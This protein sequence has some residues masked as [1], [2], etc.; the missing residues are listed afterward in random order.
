MDALAISVGNVHGT[1]NGEP[2]LDFE[3]IEKINM[4][5]ETDCIPHENSVICIP[6]I[7]MLKNITFS[8]DV[9]IINA[10][11]KKALNNNTSLNALFNSWLAG[12]VKN[13]DS[14]A[15]LETFLDKVKYVSS[16]RNFTREDMN[17]R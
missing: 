16:G 2:S 8:S 5:L 17:E 12:I 4:H 1:Y 13:D 7:K 3:R 14:A 6:V 11:R 15:E 9:K 10:A